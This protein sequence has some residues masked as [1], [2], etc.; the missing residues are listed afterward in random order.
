MQDCIIIGAG[1][2]G[3]T[4]ANYLEDK[5]FSPLIIEAT[6]RVGG[7]VK[8]DVRDGYRMDRGFQVFLP[9]Y[10][11][12]KRI[13]DYEALDLK[14]FSPGAKIL[15]EGGNI[16]MISDPLREWHTLFSTAFSRVGSIKDKWKVFELKR[17]LDK[18]AVETIFSQKGKTTKRFLLD[19]GFSEEMI[20]LFFQPFFSGIF[21]EKDL[22]TSSNMFEFVFKMFSEKSAAIPA[23]GIGE[24]PIQLKSKLEQ[25][26]FHFDERVTHIEGNKVFT[27]KHQTYEAKNIIIA[28]EAIGLV[29]QYKPTVNI[30][31]QG[32]TCL[33]FV[34]D[35]MEDMKKY[36][37][38]NGSKSK[39]INNLAVLTNVSSDYAPKGKHLIAC[40]LVGLSTEGNEDL[41]HLAKTELRKWF[42]ASVLQWQHLKT[43]HIPFAL[44][45]QLSVEINIEPTQ[46]K[47]REG[48]YIC[49]DHLLN[50]S[51]N[52]A[53]KTGR[54]VA[55]MLE[56]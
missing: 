41:V 43:Y 8:T 11:E 27:S 7:R 2:A 26:T 37:V 39:I 28:T 31:Y 44:S 36:V 1:V 33:Y 25:T 42:G 48:L 21:L 10:P 17:S 51:L 20:Q 38:I 14:Y 52:A 22:K 55:E 32:T 40:S 6:S 35:A 5:G 24:I 56:K 9:S 50:S 29:K 23:R 45:Q 49:G 53:M 47:L 30:H 18:K 15:M 34:A 16:E 3:L 54:K 19:F 46:L 12:A 4:A 13:L